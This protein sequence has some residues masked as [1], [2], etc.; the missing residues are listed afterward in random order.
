MNDIYEYKTVDSRELKMYVS[1]PQHPSPPEGYPAIVFFHG[2]SW[3]EGAP[4][5]FDEHCKYLASRGMIAIQVEYRLLNCNSDEPPTHCVRDAKSA[6]RWVR[7]QATKLMVN[8][9]RIA[10][11]GASAGGH[12]AAFSS[13]VEGMDDPLDDLTVSPRGNA[14]V[15]FNPVFDNGPDGGWGYNRVGPRY[16]EFSPAHNITRK[17]P[18]CI[19]FF[20][21][22]DQFVPIRVVHRFQ[23]NME[24]CGVRC[25][26]FIYKGQ[27]HGFFNFGT[28]E[29]IYYYKTLFETERF[30]SSLGWLT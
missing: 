7:K 19:L 8:P 1:R 21:D 9:R 23:T 20:G 16:K 12:L 29:S 30:L 26:L 28:A 2:G 18:P 6:I 5:Q 10:A 27:G 3:V 4:T 25:E 22:A 24:A 13:M 14:M 17:A 11:S 15:L